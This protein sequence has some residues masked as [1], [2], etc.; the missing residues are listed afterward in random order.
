[1]QHLRSGVDVCGRDIHQLGIAGDAGNKG[2]ARS[3]M[4]HPCQSLRE[5]RHAALSPLRSYRSISSRIASRAAYDRFPSNRSDATRSSRSMSDLSIR[6][7]KRSVF[8]IGVCVFIR[9]LLCM[10]VMCIT[11]MSRSYTVMHS[12]VNTVTTSKYET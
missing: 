7:T 5:V 6:N 12:C 11:V 4:N 10:S 3:G 8:V 2:I 1:N 9:R